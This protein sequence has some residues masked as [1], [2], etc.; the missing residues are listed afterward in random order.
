MCV[1]FQVN[2]NS[3]DEKDGI[4]IY[5]ERAVGPSGPTGIEPMTSCTPVGRSNHRGL[6]T[7]PDAVLIRRQM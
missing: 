5:H 7:I 2:I 3:I 4:F 6:L 1:V